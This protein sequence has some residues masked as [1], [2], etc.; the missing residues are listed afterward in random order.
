MREL[1]K[2]LS[3]NKKIF[4][5]LPVALISLEIYFGIVF[6][7]F[8]GKFI[9]GKKPGENG[10]I[11]SIVINFGNYKLHL[12]HWSLSL[13]ILLSNFLVSFYLPF[14]QFSLSFL[15]GLMLQGIICYPDW[16]RILIRKQ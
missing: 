7:Y 4:L 2:K 5:S 6:G 1:M 3:V 8:L 16:H 14:P 13:G 10:L 9:S 11:K 15:G 12:H